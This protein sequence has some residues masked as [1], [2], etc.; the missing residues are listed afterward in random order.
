M[1]WLGLTIGLFCG[2]SFGAVMMGIVTMG[3]LPSLEESDR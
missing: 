2:G 1:F 3:K